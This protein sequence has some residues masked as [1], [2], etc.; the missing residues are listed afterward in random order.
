MIT[1]EAAKAAP[2]T[3]CC[4]VWTNT[5]RKAKPEPRTTMPRAANPRGMYNVV[6]I[7]ANAAGNPVHSMTRQKMIQT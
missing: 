7:A 5:L 6:M 4:S 3:R 2:A 1:D